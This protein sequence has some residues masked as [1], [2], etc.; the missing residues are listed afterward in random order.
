MNRHRPKWAYTRKRQALTFD[1]IPPIYIAAICQAMNP[2]VYV[3]VC[4]MYIYIY[5]HEMKFL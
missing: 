2:T 3:Y 1:L 4:V 5:N